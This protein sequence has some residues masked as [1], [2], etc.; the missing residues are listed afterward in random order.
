MKR[1]ISMVAAIS[2]L[3]AGNALSDTLLFNNFTPTGSIYYTH[4]VNYF[5][6]TVED[7]TKGELGVE[8]TPSTL[9]PAD[10]QVEMLQYGVADV[11]IAA[12][13]WH[14]EE[15]LL[16]DVGA[17]PFSGESSLA[18]SVATWRTYER[19]FKDAYDIPGTK[20][21]GLFVHT[22][23]TLFTIDREVRDLTDIAG[24]KV[25]TVTR[26]EAEILAALGATAVERA[27]VHSYEMLNSRVVDATSTE[28]PA[29]FGFR[30]AELINH[31]FEMPQTGIASIVVIFMNEDRF[32]ALS[33]EHQQA[34]LDATGERWVRHISAEWDRR[35]PVLRD[36]LTSRGATFHRAEDSMFEPI[37]DVL[38]RFEQNWLDAAAARGVD[39]KAARAFFL[40]E[41]AKLAAEAH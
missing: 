30:S 15:F 16:F 9:A 2:L 19:Y 14:P 29:L 32:N 11:A 17:L 37:R 3:G 12:T 35:L 8:I 7:L 40:E 24:L 1:L 36:Q 13:S 18:G 23:K 34:V 21:L 6:E 22:P 25:Q 20:L 41:Y 10:G 27:Q 39:A 38:D 33:K 4:G 5:K 28:Y 26:A 31:I